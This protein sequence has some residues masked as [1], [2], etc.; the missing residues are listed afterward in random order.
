MNALQE[1]STIDLRSL[2]NSENLHYL[3]T[4]EFNLQPKIKNQLHQGISSSGRK[5]SESHQ[6]LEGVSMMAMDD[7]LRCDEEVSDFKQGHFSS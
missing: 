5:D 3:Q 6:G 1:I 2:M 4:L 7:E